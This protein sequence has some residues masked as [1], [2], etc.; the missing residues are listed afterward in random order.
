M[1]INGL[2]SVK[3][4]QERATFRTCDELCVY[5]QVFSFAMPESVNNNDDL[6]IRL[7]EKANSKIAPVISLPAAYITGYEQVQY[8]IQ[9]GVK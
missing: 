6:E 5:D 4:K 1:S 7:Q 9:H 3:I 2:E 8:K